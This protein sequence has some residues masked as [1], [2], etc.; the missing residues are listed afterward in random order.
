MEYG[1]LKEQEIREAFNNLVR[2]NGRIKSIYQ[3]IEK[4]IATYD[5]ANIFAGEVGKILASVF[6]DTVVQFDE[7]TLRVVDN[8]L[9][10]NE[11]VVSKVCESIQENL[12]SIAK[13]G[14]K[15]IKPSKEILENKRVGV[16]ESIIDRPVEKGLVMLNQNT[17]TNILAVVDSY[18]KVN[19]DFQARA[20]L[21]PVIVRKWDGITGSHDT[22]HTDWCK[23]LQGT[24]K[25]GTEPKNVYRRHQGCGCMIA[26]FPDRK[27]KGIITALAKGQKDDNGALRNVAYG[28]DI[29]KILTSEWE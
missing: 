6:G 4:G 13:I 12:N 1:S 21:E 26:Y 11:V 29:Q 10:Q 2:K 5:D 23:D 22:R 18:V 14:I 7:D 8:M 25:Y 19:A 3:R 20:G 15:P 16:L 9:L 28:E 24:F 27:T 17:K